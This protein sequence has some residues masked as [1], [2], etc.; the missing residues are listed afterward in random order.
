MRRLVPYPGSKSGMA[1]LQTNYFPEERFNKFWETNGGTGAMTTN[2]VSGYEMDAM[3]ITELDIGMYSLLK[4]VQEDPYSLVEELSKTQYSAWEFEE[5]KEAEEV[6]YRDMTQLEIAMAK[7]IVCRQSF[8]GQG[9]NYRDIDLGAEDD[10]KCWSNAQWQRNKYLRQIP[11]LIEYSQGLQ[12]VQIIHSDFLAYFDKFAANS[13]MFIYSDIPYYNELRSSGLYREETDKEW[14]RRYAMK[15]R[16][17]TEDGSL[18]AKV[19]LCGYVNENMKADLYCNELLPAGWTLYLIK[20]VYRPTII[21]DNSK[22]RKKGKAIEAVFLNYKP[23]NPL[24]G[25]ERI[26]TY[27]D[28]F[29]NN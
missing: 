9:K 16:K 26:F 4:Q 3:Y 27:D 18:K 21:K 29:G 7:W 19:M 12:G 8:N 20:D 23:I 22:S 5:A 24:V 2:I 25:K 17:M 11:Q 1:A 6:G 28:V 13:E 15:L 10:V 14:H